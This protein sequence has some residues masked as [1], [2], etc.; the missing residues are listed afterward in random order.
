MKKLTTTLLMVLVLPIASYQTWDYLNNKL[1]VYSDVMGA[2]E[3]Y[4]G[5]AEYYSGHCIEDG[6]ATWQYKEREL[7]EKEAELNK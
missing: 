1:T 7:A 4:T 6:S 5:G 3:C 2:V